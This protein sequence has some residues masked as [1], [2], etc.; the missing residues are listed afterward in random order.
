MLTK[1]IK[2][3][4]NYIALKVGQ[5]LAISIAIVAIGLVLISDHLQVQT[6]KLFVPNKQF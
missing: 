4:S 6:T 1:V 5:L 3:K 2:L